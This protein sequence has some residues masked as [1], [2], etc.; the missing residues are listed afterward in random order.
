MGRFKY[1]LDEKR[2]FE[3]YRD[4]S[5]VPRTEGAFKFIPSDKYSLIE[6]IQT[7]LDRDGLRCSD[8][9]VVNSYNR[10]RENRFIVKGEKEIPD[11]LSSG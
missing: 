1:T 6:E 2:D 4:S 10:K 11:N 7:L 8:I 3:K 5:Q 9:A